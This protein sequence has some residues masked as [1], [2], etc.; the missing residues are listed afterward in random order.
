MYD[1]QSAP[2]KALGARR[3]TGCHGTGTAQ[4]T[5]CDVGAISNGRA[6]LW[7]AESLD[8]IDAFSDEATQECPNG[9]GATCPCL[10]SSANDQHHGRRTANRG[11]EG[12][13]P[14][15]LSLLLLL[16]GQT[17]SRRGTQGNLT[18]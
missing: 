14:L 16:Q 12:L 3:P 9:D 13:R 1:E 15:F 10:Q 5:G 6:S 2:D 17:N 7:D 8:G 18:A 4:Y 11:D